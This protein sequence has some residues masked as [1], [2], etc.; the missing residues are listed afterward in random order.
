MQNF[1]ADFSQ[2]DTVI[3]HDGR[4]MTIH[5]VEVLDSGSDTALKPPLVFLPGYGTGAAIFVRCWS[6]LLLRERLPLIA[7]DVLGSFL[8]SHPTWTPGTDV[9]KAE[10]WFV[11]SL[12]AWRRERQ[13]TQL[14]L[15][16]HSIGGNI[17]AAY[18]ESYPESVRS[19]ILVSPAGMVGEP[20]DYQTKLRSASRRIRLV[21]SLWRRGWTPFSAV[22]LLPESYAR[23]ICLWNAR[24]WSGHRRLDHVDDPAVTALADYIYHGWREGPASGDVAIAALLHPGAWGKKPLGARLPKISVS[25]LEIIYGTRDWMDMRHGNRVAEACAEQRTSQAPAPVV[26][27]QVV[28]GAGHYAHLE[29]VDGFVE[30]LACALKP[31]S[32]GVCVTAPLPDGYEEQFTGPRIP[33]WRS[34]EGYSFGR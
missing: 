11:E 18:A 32:E 25:R 24:R 21:M 17:A 12:E 1:V 30:A 28:D 16:G 33:A 34:W 2:R 7:V 27:V 5:S 13:I 10:A 3:K 9:E 15:L 23:R 4:D 8:S 20:E 31:R 22:R 6:Q 14:D 19:L 29:N 26:C